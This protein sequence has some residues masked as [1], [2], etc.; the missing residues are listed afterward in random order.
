[1][2]VFEKKFLFLQRSQEKRG[3]CGQTLEMIMSVYKVYYKTFK[4]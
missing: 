1:M 2:F 4:F 3:G